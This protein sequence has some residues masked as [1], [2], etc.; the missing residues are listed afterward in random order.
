MLHGFDKDDIVDYIP[1]CERGSEDPCI[2]RLRFV[3]FSK[4]Q[5]YAKLLSART[6]GM[7]NEEKRTAVAQAVQ[8]KQ[9]VESVD[10]ISG[11]YVRDKEV[12][13]AETFYETAETDLIYEVIRAMESAAKLSE[14]QA[15]NF[16]SPSVINEEAAPSTATPAPILT[17]SKGTAPTVTILKEA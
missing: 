17:E 16:E 4:V 14:G 9:F 11:Y 1:E 7:S 5:K 10:S 13:D 8:R 12:T 15:K 6:K 3:P 2:I